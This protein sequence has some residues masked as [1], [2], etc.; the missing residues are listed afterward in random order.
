MKKM[1]DEQL[2]RIRDYASTPS[3]RR[4]ARRELEARETRKTHPTPPPESIAPD[5]AALALIDVSSIWCEAEE[6]PY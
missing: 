2:R 4:K 6:I 5:D 3:Q 1:S